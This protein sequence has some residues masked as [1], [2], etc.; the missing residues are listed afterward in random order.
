VRAE[1]HR[2]NIRLPET[3]GDGYIP[4]R[5]EAALTPVGGE[6]RFAMCLADPDQFER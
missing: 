6:G 3:V 4:L 2:S 1:H 5:S